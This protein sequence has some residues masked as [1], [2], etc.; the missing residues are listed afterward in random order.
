MDAELR[1][2]Q[3]FGMNR[4]VFEVQQLQRDVLA[5]FA[6]AVHLEPVGL[7]PTRSEFFFR[8]SEQPCLDGRLPETAVR[9]QP[10][11]LYGFNRFACT[12]PAETPVRFRPFY[13]ENSSTRGTVDWVP[14]VMHLHDVLRVGVS[15]ALSGRW[16]RWKPA[17]AFARSRQSTLTNPE[18]RPRYPTPAAEANQPGP[19]VRGTSG[20]PKSS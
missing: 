5:A 15:L 9:H 11:S 6:L 17:T 1:I 8:A 10:K 13:T 3:P 7:W 18:C 14:I 16:S 4:F 12:T 2:A 19:A 20:K